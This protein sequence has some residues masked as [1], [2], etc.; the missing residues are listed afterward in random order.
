MYANSY[1][2]NAIGAGMPPGSLNINNS[3]HGGKC[4]IFLLIFLVAMLK[5]FNVVKLECCE[6]F[7]GPNKKENPAITARFDTLSMKLKSPN[8]TTFQRYNIPTK[9][10]S[11]SQ[12]AI[13][14]SGAS[15]LPYV[16]GNRLV[17]FLLRVSFCFPGSARGSFCRQPSNG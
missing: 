2:G 11:S 10:T 4:S 12:A 1:F 7:T 14:V 6:T 8:I 3:I 17:S 5:S 9:I 13:A 15:F 16:P